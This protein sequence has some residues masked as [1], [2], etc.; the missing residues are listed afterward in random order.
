[1]K[2]RSVLVVSC[3]AL[4]L[5]ACDKKKSDATPPPAPGTASG[6]TTPPPAVPPAPPAPAAGSGTAAAPADGELRIPN[7]PAKVGDKFTETEDR[8]MVAKIE[9]KPGQAIEVTTREQRQEDKEVVAVD[10]GVI[11]KLKVSYPKVVITES[12]MGQTKDKPTPTAGKSYLVWREGGALKATLADGA[13]VSPEEMKVLAKGQKSVGRP[14]VMQQIMAEHAWKLGETVAMSPA[15]IARLADV[16]GGEDDAGKLI[17]MGFTLQASDAT[18]AT[19]AMT[20]AMESTGAKGTMK[21]SLTG[22]A[23]VDRNSGRALEVSAAGPFEGNMGVPITG[24]MTATTSYA[25]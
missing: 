2:L 11:S 12:A 23:K 3:L 22:T 1:M 18:T 17:A 14:D 7:L 19:F 9:P 8:T 16:V 13:A 21:V 25:Y 20:M 15:E 4:A 6:S 24:T 5:G 10:G